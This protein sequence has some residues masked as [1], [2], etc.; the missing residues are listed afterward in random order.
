VLPLEFTAHKPKSFN[1]KGA[2]DAKKYFS[3]GRFATRKA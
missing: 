2:K 1:A 3:N